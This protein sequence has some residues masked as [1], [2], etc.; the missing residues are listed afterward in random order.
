MHTGRNWIESLPADLARHQQV[1]ARLLAHCETAPA[2]TSFSVGCSI[3][4]RAADSLSDIDAAIGVLAPRGATGTE[5]LRSVEQAT[6]ELLPGWGPLVDVLRQET[7]GAGF[8]LRRLF[9]QY[10]DGLQLDLAI[11]ADG[12]IRRGEAAPDFV[13]LY[14]SGPEPEPTDHPSAFGASQ[15]QLCEWVFLGWR[16]LL[17]ADKYLRRG[18][19]WEVHQRLHETRDHIWK[20]W[21]TGRDALYPWH[22][23]SQVLDHAPDLLP[24]RIEDTV[25]GLDRDDLGRAVLVAADVLVQAT[26]CAER[27]TGTRLCLPIADYARRRLAHGADVSGTP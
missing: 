8:V 14:R 16:A 24:D 9:A 20:L 12:D 6:V 19:M 26:A 10:D 21:A 1:L 7:H 22:G 17:D 25:A 4:R 3:G 2:I 15:A 18:S 11:V 27:T 5:V 23:L 13:E